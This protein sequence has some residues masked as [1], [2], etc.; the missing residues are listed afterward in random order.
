MSISDSPLWYVTLAALH[1]APLQE[2]LRL[3]VPQSDEPRYHAE[4]LKG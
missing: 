3:R 1:E 4:V 2:K